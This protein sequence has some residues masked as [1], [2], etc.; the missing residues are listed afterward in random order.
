MTQ[1]LGISPAM[2]DEQRNNIGGII[3]QFGKR[4]S[5]FIRKRVR[6]EEDAEDILQDVWYQL[7]SVV[8]LNTIENAGSWLFTVARNRITDSY[9]KKKP[10]LLDDMVPPDEDG[11]FLNADFRSI[12]LDDSKNPEM[13]VLRAAFWETLEEALAE[14]PE[15]QRRVFLLHEIE[16]MSYQDIAE[17][18][19]ENIN[20]L[21]SR[22]RYAVLHL[23]KKLQQLYDEILNH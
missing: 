5:A 9:R 3:N 18:T 20:T 22:K 4:L 17:Q 1:P 10:V 8:D 2:S 11:D 16:D 19:G 12:L 7:T 14:L 21:L 15:E 6:T 23:R 13:E